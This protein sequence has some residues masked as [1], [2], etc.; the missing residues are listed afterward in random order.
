[1]VGCLCACI[2][3]ETI[4]QY[5]WV[6][7]HWESSAL[8]CRVLSSVFM[9][10]RQ[11]SESRRCKISWT[12]FGWWRLTV[13]SHGAEKVKGAFK[14]V[15]SY[16]KIKLD[17]FSELLYTWRCAVCASEA[18]TETLRTV[19]CLNNHRYLIEDF[20]WKKSVFKHKG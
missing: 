15:P 6:G 3:E 9:C 7:G 17:F 4:F 10:S 2:T 5:D 20:L 19:V 18:R 11:E 16:N 13:V 1:M 12:V 8:Q 14:E